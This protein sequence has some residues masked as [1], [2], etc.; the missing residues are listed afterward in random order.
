M[1]ISSISPVTILCGP[2]LYCCCRLCFP[3]LDWCLARILAFGCLGPSLH[4]CYWSGPI[5]EQWC[6]KLAVPSLATLVG[7][8]DALRQ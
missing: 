4:W 5:L 3:S 8:I 2:N 6:W 1:I 7:P